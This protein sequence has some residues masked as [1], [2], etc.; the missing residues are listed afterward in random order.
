MKRRL[1]LITLALVLM[2]MALAPATALAA[3]PQSFNAAGVIDEIEAT[4]IGENVFPAGNSGRWRVVGREIGGELSGDVNGRFSMT[5][6][7]NIESTETQ[8][9]SL[10][11]T[12]DV[13]EYSF[14]VNGKIRPLEIVDIV[15]IDP[16]TYYPILKLTIDGHWSLPGGPGNGEFYGWVIFIPDENG[17]VAFIEASSFSMT[18]KW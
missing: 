18:G 10:H 14:K 9:G 3:K 17:H 13:G 11:G 16:E 8:A 12:L 2:L 1:L 7:A 15:W 4:V 5:Y 6:K